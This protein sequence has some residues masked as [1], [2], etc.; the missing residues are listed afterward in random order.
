MA[1]SEVLK[2][3]RAIMI[4]WTSVKILNWG[5]YWSSWRFLRFLEKNLYRIW[6]TLQKMYICKVRVKMTHQHTVIRLHCHCF[7]D[8]AIERHR[9]KILLRRLVSRQSIYSWYPNKNP[10]SSLLFEPRLLRRGTLTYRF[11]LTILLMVKWRWLTLLLATPVLFWVQKHRSL[12]WMN[13]SVSVCPLFR[14]M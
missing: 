13:L 12:R 8:T 7:F 10:C 6:H 5:K 4:D 3:A 9:W 11:F 2:E 1:A 14:K